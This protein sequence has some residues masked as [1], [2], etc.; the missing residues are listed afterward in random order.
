MSDVVTFYRKSDGSPVHTNEHRFDAELMT[1]EPPGE[2][3]QAETAEDSAE[4]QDDSAAEEAPR[5]G[6]GRPR[7]NP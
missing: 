6:P 1:R 3:A 5:R 4:N 2:E 7:K